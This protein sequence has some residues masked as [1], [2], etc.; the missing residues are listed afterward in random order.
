MS[1]HVSTWGTTSAWGAS[2]TMTN[3]ILNIGKLVRYC[4][5]PQCRDP[6]QIKDNGKHHQ[7]NGTG[8]MDKLWTSRMETWDIINENFVL[9]IA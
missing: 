6:Q 7:G 8:T 2:K 3:G 5:W 9:N 1:L 4:L